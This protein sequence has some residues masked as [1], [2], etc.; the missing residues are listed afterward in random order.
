[1]TAIPRR[2][3][4]T[5]AA[6]E[7]QDALI[8]FSAGTQVADTAAIAKFTRAGNKFQGVVTELSK[9]Y[10]SPT[11]ANDNKPIVEIDGQTLLGKDFPPVKYIVPGYIAEGLTLLGGRPKLGKSWLAL[12]MC[13]AVATGGRSLGEECEE[14]DVLYAALEDNQRRLQDRL[15]KVLPPLKSLWP[16]LSR[17]RFWNTSPRIG[18]GLLERLDE[19]RKAAEDPRLIVIDTLAMVRPPK[20]RTQDSYEADY[21][22]LSPLQ[23]YA[24][25]HRIAIIVITHVRK[26]EA[27][28]PLEMISG[29]NGLTGAA[30]TIMVLDRSG[31]GSKIVGRGRDIEEIEKALRFEAGKWTVLGDADDVRRSGQ[32]RKILDALKEAELP[33]KPAEIATATGM[34]ADGIRHLLPKM[35]T[36]GEVE[37]LAYGTYR[38]AKE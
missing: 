29:T 23:T 30:D 20:A 22:A 1:M 18:A 26:A 28:D 11:A 10:D 15:K 34:R 21:A 12:D 36:A 31:E 9:K 13:I 33:M 3:N 38:A 32:R 8:E 25:E 16:N 6:E 35:V 19:W 17:L 4:F 2:P 5:Q 27:A 37:K 24:S 7:F 14:G